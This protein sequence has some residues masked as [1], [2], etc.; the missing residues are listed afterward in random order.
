MSPPV[1][2]EIIELSHALRLVPVVEFAASSYA[3]ET[4][5]SP[6]GSAQEMPEAW[7]RYWTRSLADSGLE[8]LEPIAPAS[9]LVPLS[10]LTEPHV[11]RALLGVHLALLSGEEDE[12]PDGLLPLSGGQAL[13]DGGRVLLVPGCCAD[14][15]NLGSWEATARRECDTFWMGH[16][17][18]SARW[19]SPWVRLQDEASTEGGPAREW[20]LA[21]PAILRAARE[22]RTEQEAFALRL[23][24]LVAE[25]FPAESVHEIASLLAGLR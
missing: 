2:R 5:A 8:G 12:T 11:L 20:R 16:P 18:V 14:L 4:H 10:R 3:R 21:P 17:L 24:P 7:R 25:R 22:A 19:E 9:P 1:P 6:E 15:G 13:L 23:E